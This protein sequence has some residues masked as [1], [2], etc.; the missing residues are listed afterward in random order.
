MKQNQHHQSVTVNLSERSYN[1][2]IG[3]N[4]LKQADKYI[5]PLLQHARVAI[6]TDV[7]VA[8]LHLYK[9]I[10]SLRTVGVVPVVLELPVGESTKSWSEF[11]KAVEWLL[12]QR[13]ER[14]DIIIALGGGVIGDL[15]GFA[16]ATLRRGVRYIQIPT[17]LLAQADSSVGGKT[18]INSPQ[19]KNLI[20]VFHQPALVLADID[21]LKTLPK[22]E[23][24]SGY[25]EVA[26]YGLLGNIKF[27]SWLE[28]NGQS[29]AAG[30]TKGR[31]KAVTMSV[32]TK[33]RIV[34]QDEKE[35]GD[36]KL[37]NL[38]H[39]F[40]HVLE[41]ATGYSKRLL[42]GEGVAIGCVL[43]FE[44]SS[45]LGLCSQEVPTRISKHFRDMN[46]RVSLSEIEGDLPDAEALFNLMQQDK[47]IIDGSLQ[48]ILAQDI[49]KAIIAKD[50]PSHLVKEI[51]S[52]SRS[53]TDYF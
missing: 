10:E 8:T 29:L 25:A 30:E 20:G 4:L 16:A 41:A 7:N 37:L 50:I 32:E 14:Q 2:E 53:S 18:G 21:T 31:L 24:L 42:H 12:K 45:K 23:F 19:G 34:E 15:V 39:T 49:G 43:A 3:T 52:D 51:L 5:S 9:L 13:I 48:F 40:C 22:R 46:L 36:R 38:G 27:F 11:S 17:T 47:K 28:K 33:A 1:V 35:S 6:L 26:K 44:L